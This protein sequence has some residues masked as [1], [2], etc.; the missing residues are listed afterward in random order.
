[1][2]IKNLIL[3]WCLL[4][5]AII[6]ASTNGFQLRPSQPIALSDSVAGT[7]LFVCPAASPGF[8]SAAKE[9][10]V[11]RQALS[12]AF[13]FLALLW[14]ALT[15]WAVYVS[16]LN[17]KFEHK[18]YEIP[19]FLAKFLIFSFVLAIIM[20]KTPNHFRRVFVQGAEGAWVLCE[21]DTPGAKAVRQ[22]AVFADGK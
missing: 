11:Y 19:I 12:I 22:E 14:A 2:K 7:A 9:L 18:P 15:A 17:D 6:V 16:L 3:L 13:M 20:L 5:I 10:G 4:G 21:R 1:M 8:E